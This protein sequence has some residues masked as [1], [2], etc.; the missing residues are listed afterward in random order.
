M[1]IRLYS[2]STD[3]DALFLTMLSFAAIL[4]S[5]VLTIDTTFLGLFFLFLL[6]GAATFVGLEMRRGS[7]GALAPEVDA[8]PH[9]ERRLAHALVLPP[10]SVALD[11][12]LVVAP[13]VF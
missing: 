10:L 1:L 5:A 11:A 9:K 12:V 6:F 2:A 13:L 7:K 4:A 8:Q 3:R